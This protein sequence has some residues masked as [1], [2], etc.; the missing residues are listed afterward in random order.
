MLN[1]QT[2]FCIIHLV[3]R[4]ILELSPIATWRLK[5][6]MNTTDVDRSIQRR[7]EI[8]EC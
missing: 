4:L 7:P 5:T 3:Y 6:V 8:R 1:Q 2:I